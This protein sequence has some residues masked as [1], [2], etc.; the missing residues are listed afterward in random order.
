HA[1]DEESGPGRPDR[2]LLRL[3]RRGGGAR[4]QADACR[5]ELSMGTLARAAALREASRGRDQGPREDRG[6]SVADPDQGGR[7]VERHPRRLWGYGLVRRAYWPE[8][9]PLS[10]V[11]SLPFLPISSA[12]KGSEALWKLY[13]KFPSVQKEYNEIEPL[14]LYTSSPNLLVS[15]R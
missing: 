8:Q 4:D 3:G 11:M 1:R 13:E 9:T 6:L 7:H 5:P 14:L 2:C 12:E 15:K 10:D